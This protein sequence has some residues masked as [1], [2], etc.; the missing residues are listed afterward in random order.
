MDPNASFEE[1]VAA[2]AGRLETPTKAVGAGSRGRT[3]RPPALSPVVAAA[4]A[5]GGAQQERKQYKRISTSYGLRKLPK[6]PGCRKCKGNARG[7]HT[8]GHQLE[9]ASDEQVRSSSVLLY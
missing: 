2:V 6:P 9:D 1:L 8:K 3:K 5:P 7:C 4:T